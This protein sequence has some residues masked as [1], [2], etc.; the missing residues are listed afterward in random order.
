M[1]AEFMVKEELAVIRTESTPIVPEFPAFETNTLDVES[2][3]V[4]ATICSPPTRVML[5]A[6]KGR[7]L[8]LQSN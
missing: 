1:F 6:F 3:L 4:S 2:I 7:W 5:P 8:I